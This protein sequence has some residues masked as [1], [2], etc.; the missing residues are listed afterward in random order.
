MPITGEIMIDWQI[1]FHIFFTNK[2]EKRETFKHKTNNQLCSAITIWRERNTHSFTSLIDCRKN[3]RLFLFNSNILIE[4]KKTF[5]RVFF[6]INIFSSWIE[7]KKRHWTNKFSW[8]KPQWPIDYT[9][10]KTD[11]WLDWG[12]GRGVVFCVEPLSRGKS[13]C[14]QSLVFAVIFFLTNATP[15]PLKFK[16]NHLFPRFQLLF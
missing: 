14:A 1:N 13:R 11:L 6:Q 8:R 5:K 7:D 2:S 3:E 15:I 10:G 16:L 4:E 9:K 12:G